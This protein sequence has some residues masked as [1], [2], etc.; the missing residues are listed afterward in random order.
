A[1]T[2]TLMRS[3]QLSAAQTGIQG[4]R[5]LSAWLLVA[6]LVLYGVAIWLA[7]GARRATL[8]NAGLG[9]A[10]V[11]L[12]VLVIRHLLGNYLVSSL[13]APGY[14]HTTHRLWLIG[15]SILGQIGSAALLYG[16][17][18]ALGAMLAGPT[19]IATRVRSWFAPVLNEQPAVAWGTVAFAYLLL[20]LWGGT[21]ALRVWWGILLLGGLLALGVFALRL[22]TLQEFPPGTAALPAAAG[23]DPSATDELERLTALHT[24]GAI[25]DAEFEAAKK[26]ALT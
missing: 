9:L 15:T 24:A 23:A 14:E 25:D 21:H 5:V 11:G 2:I 4:V 16:L 7:R 13:S 3:D 22:Q 1:G 19:G 17:V 6:V 18:A 8:R 12:L 10:L 26:A 20:L